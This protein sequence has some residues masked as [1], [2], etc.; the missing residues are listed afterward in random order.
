[1]H[2]E[3]SSGRV[4]SRCFFSTF[5]VA[6]RWV[7]PPTT[8]TASPQPPLPSTPWPPALPL[9]CVLLWGKVALLRPLVTFTTFLNIFSQRGRARPNWARVPGWTR[10]WRS[11]TDQCTQDSSQVW[12]GWRGLVW[13]GQTSVLRTPLRFDFSKQECSQNWNLLDLKQMPNIRCASISWT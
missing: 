9:K 6:N 11:R 4:A 13:F 10:L 1:M 3:S 7:W 8:A 5:L 12:F 2:N